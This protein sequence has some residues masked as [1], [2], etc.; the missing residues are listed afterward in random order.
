MCSQDTWWKNGNHWILCH[1]TKSTRWATSPPRTSSWWRRRITPSVTQCTA[2]TPT[3]INTYRS[4]VF[5]CSHKVY[6]SMASHYVHPHTQTSCFLKSWHIPYCT[7]GPFSQRER[8]HAGSLCCT[9]GLTMC[10]M[11][12]FLSL[13]ISLIRY[14]SLWFL[15]LVELFNT[16]IIFNLLSV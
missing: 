13:C 2:R 6:L 14:A 8:H 10:S 7:I 15:S 11:T 3:Q 5:S 12:F 4:F 1:L 9:I 16:I